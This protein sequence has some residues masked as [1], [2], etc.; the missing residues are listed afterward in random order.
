MTPRP[1]GQAARRS[2]DQIRSIS[3]GRSGG[4]QP[5]PND[6]ARTASSERTAATMAFIGTKPPPESDPRVALRQGC[7]VGML[8]RRFGVAVTV[9]GRRVQISQMQTDLLEGVLEDVA[10]RNR[11]AQADGLS[12]GGECEC[13]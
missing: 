13:E 2:E 3:G 9:L 4:S 12:E 1:Q 10:G 7:V 11:Q 8:D 6:G 5:V